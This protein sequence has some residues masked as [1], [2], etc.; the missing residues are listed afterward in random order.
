[1]LCIDENVI[2]KRYKE[3]K[4]DE[5]AEVEEANCQCQND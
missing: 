3:E 2:E 5:I 1:M 4:E